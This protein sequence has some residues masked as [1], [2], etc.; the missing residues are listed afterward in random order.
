MNETNKKINVL[1]HTFNAL[2]H[3]IIRKIKDSKL[4]GNIYIISNNKP[5]DVDCIYLGSFSNIKFGELKKIVKEKEIDFAIS[6]QE[7]Y[8]ISGLINFFQE[9]INL[10]AIGVTKEWFELEYSK[11][12]GKEFMA[13]NGIVSPEYVTVEKI[14]ELENAISSFGLPIVIKNNF[15]EAG[16]GAHICK[17]KKSALKFA[18]KIIKEHKFCIAEKF[19]QG[20]EISQQYFWD[21][22][23]LLPMLPVKDFKRP[24]DNTDS[25]N[26]GGLACYT[27]VMLTENEN[28]LLEKYN[29]KLSEI[30]KKE[31]PDFTGI[32]TANLLFTSDKLYTL[33]FNMRPGIA[34]FETLIE[35]LD[36]DLLK[37]LYNCAYNNL[38]EILQY[39]EGI[40]GC[41]TVAHKDYLKH[42]V[43][44][45]VDISLKKNI[46]PWDNDIKLNFNAKFNS[47]NKKLN[48]LK[49]QRFL[50]VICTDR[51]DPFSKI[52]DYLDNIDSKKIYYRKNI[53]YE[54]RHS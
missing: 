7:S 53:K 10:P 33:E 51:I 5:F 35:H 19:V 22:N 25:V 11:L 34:E 49:I 50:S 48:F 36:C 28:K 12:K 54:K 44:K 24:N 26:T 40:T 3:G 2:T 38:N 32:F 41:I 15:L 37:I 23:T 30:F 27:P 31:K 4:L 46:L 6:F 16:F 8:S 1:I 20:F 21:K 13:A 18:K 47:K 17:D 9:K 39:K 29:L 42:K 43:V 52:Y 45:A 14:D